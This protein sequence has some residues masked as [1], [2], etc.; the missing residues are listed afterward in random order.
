[1]TDRLYNVRFLCTGESARSQIAECVMNRLGRGRIR[2]DSAGSHPNDEVRPFAL[3]LLQ[4]ENYQTD[5]LRSKSWEAFAG[6][7]APGMDFVFTVCDNAASEACPIW[8]GQPMSAH[9]PIPDPAAA[10]G[11]E[12]ERHL[13]FAQA[14]RMLTQRIDMFLNLP[15]SSLGRLALQKRLDEIGKARAP[16]E[17]P[18]LSMKRT[19][20]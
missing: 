7:E 12:A 17:A 8:P 4:R 3:Q 14:L 5:Q 16:D 10:E 19:D 15:L 1:M 11:N 2:A 13:A 6:P 20:S 9:W 18:E